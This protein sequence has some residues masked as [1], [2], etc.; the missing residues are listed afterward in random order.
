MLI[1]SFEISKKQS[2]AMH[3]Q[4]CNVHSCL[5]GTWNKR[6]IYHQHSKNLFLGNTAHNLR[7]TKTQILS[8]DNCGII[9]LSVY[10]CSHIVTLL[11]I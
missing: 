10:T 7:F 3:I 2:A 5:L 1:R 9:I 8:I 11:V 4:V 6:L